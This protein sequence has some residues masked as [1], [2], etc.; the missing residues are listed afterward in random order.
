MSTIA[1]FDSPL[2]GYVAFRKENVA[3][4]YIIVNLTRTVDNR[5]RQDEELKWEIRGTD[6]S[7]RDSLYNPDSVPTEDAEYNGNCDPSSDT[8]HQSCAAGDLWKKHGRLKINNGLQINLMMFV[9]NNLASAETLSQGQNLVILNT[10]NK[11]NGTIEQIVAWSK[12]ESLE[13]VSTN[14]PFMDGS[15][16]LLLQRDDWSPVGQSYQSAH[17]NTP[18][19]WE[20]SIYGLPPLQI[21]GGDQWDCDEIKTKGWSYSSSKM[22]DLPPF[23][24]SYFMNCISGNLIHFSRILYKTIAP[25]SSV[26]KQ[27]FE[28]EFFKLLASVQLQFVQYFIVIRVS[29]LRIHKFMPILIRVC[30]DNPWNDIITD[31]A[32]SEVSQPNLHTVRT[33][34]HDVPR[35]RHQTRKRRQVQVCHHHVQTGSL[36]TT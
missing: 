24:V 1:W 17:Q 27:P 3:V 23:K 7:S 10:T 26:V 15:S 33:K 14:I 18:G 11:A 32:R 22:L 36:F 8:G 29:N 12:I 35:C 4:S 31:I 28:Y 19:K 16:L 21:F 6:I 20:V 30:I 5:D 34:L 25:Y 13:P 2:T 9:D